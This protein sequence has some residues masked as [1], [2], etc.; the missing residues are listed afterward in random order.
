MIEPALR[1]RQRLI[2]SSLLALIVITI[3]IGMGMGYASLSYDRLIPTI[4]GQGSF[5]EEF[6]L[7]S[8]RLPRILITLLAGMGLAL[9]GAIL[10]GTARLAADSDR[11]DRGRLLH[12]AVRG[13][14][15]PDLLGGA[16]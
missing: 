12:G 6:V 9:S 1:L 11:P 2:V 15:R 7:F 14:D 4:L 16:H 5:K 8:V 3:V 13:N 10:Q